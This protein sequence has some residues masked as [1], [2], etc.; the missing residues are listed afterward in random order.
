M[1]ASVPLTS[2]SSGLRT[3]MAKTYSS[4]IRRRSVSDG[5]LR[6]SFTRRHS[7]ISSVSPSQT[8]A[9]SASL[10]CCSSSPKRRSAVGLVSF[11]L[12]YPAHAEC[13]RG[14]DSYTRR[15]R[16]QASLP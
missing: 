3:I 15:S 2:T 8:A 13:G 5:G 14:C 11:E 7:R 1:K 4:A 6:M 12:K 16:R 10:I 9:Y